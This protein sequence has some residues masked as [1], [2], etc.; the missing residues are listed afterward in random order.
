MK[1]YTTCTVWFRRRR[2]ILL[3]IIFIASCGK[4][5]D[6]NGFDWEADLPLSDSV[7][8]RDIQ[9]LDLGINNI[10][11]PH[12]P[13]DAEDPLFF[14]LEQFSSVPINY[15]VSDRW[16]VSFSDMYR[17]AIGPN[18]GSI[19]GFGYGSSATGG[20]LVLEQPYSEVLDVPA[21]DQFRTNG[22]IGLLGFGDG[23]IPG[24]YVFVTFFGNIFRPDLADDD[25]GFGHPYYFLMYCFSEDF[26]KTFPGEY[27]T[28]GLKATPRTLIV[29]T[30]KGNY[31]KL[32]MQSMYK[33]IMDPLEMRRGL[34]EHPVGY[35]SF[36]YMIIKKEEKR[37]GFVPRKP[38]LTVNLSTKTRT[39]GN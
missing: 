24:G 6:R 13:L 21:D 16:D 22:S 14:S 30:A 4:V 31:A 7:F 11:E 8:N 23:A 33:G 15:R 28:G 19:P 1:I 39:T 9:I 2:L 17:H 3:G 29:R 12:H 36:R 27:G 35:M 20:I 32:E 10:P 26:Q 37:F 38:S 5:F 18:N 25:L 34:L